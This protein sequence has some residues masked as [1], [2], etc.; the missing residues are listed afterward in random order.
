MRVILRSL[1]RM[2]LLAVPIS[3]E[4]CTIS[5]D[6]AVK[7]VLVPLTWATVAVEFSTPVAASWMIS[8]NPFSSPR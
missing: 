5:A 3:S 6:R 2:A 4:S 8:P 1:I 7:A